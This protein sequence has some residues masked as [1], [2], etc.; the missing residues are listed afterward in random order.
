MCGLPHTCLRNKLSYKTAVVGIFKRCL[1]AY[2]G[3]WFRHFSHYPIF[4]SDLQES[5]DHHFSRVNEGRRG[6]GVSQPGKGTV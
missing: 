1:K 3:P 6:F 2:L 5:D 4:S